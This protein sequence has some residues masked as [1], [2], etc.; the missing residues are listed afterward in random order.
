MRTHC[1]LKPQYTLHGQV[2][3]SVTLSPPPSSLDIV[4]VIGSV[5]F[6]LPLHLVLHL[7]VSQVFWFTICLGDQ[8]VYPSLLTMATMRKRNVWFLKFTEAL[9][10]LT[11]FPF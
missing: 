5:E 9:L 1:N 6:C 10:G 2:T 3:V 8:A 7:V 4:S 11:G